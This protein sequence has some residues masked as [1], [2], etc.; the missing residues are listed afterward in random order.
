M[1][2]C[3]I[4]KETEAERNL[5]VITCPVKGVELALNLGSHPLSPCCPSPSD[6]QMSPKC[7]CCDLPASWPNNYRS[8]GC[9]GL[10]SLVL[11]LSYLNPGKGV[12]EVKRWNA[13][14][15]PLASGSLQNRPPARGRCLDF[16]S[17]AFPADT[18]QGPP[19]YLTGSLPAPPFFAR[20]FKAMHTCGH[21][22]FS[23][24]PQS[25]W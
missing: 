3:F 17:Q 11:P 25:V 18:H 1:L 14:C 7:Q 13:E 4:S 23:P 20:V 6:L 12:K 8:P 10:Y 9:K 19:P 16:R 22:H 2:S 21:T 24:S 15:L 5:D